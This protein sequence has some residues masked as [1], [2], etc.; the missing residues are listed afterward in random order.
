MV[1]MYRSW[2]DLRLD[3]DFE[4]PRSTSNRASTAPEPHDCWFS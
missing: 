4:G 1:L 3:L 2:Q